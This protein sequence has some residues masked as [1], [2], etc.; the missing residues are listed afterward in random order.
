[1][2]KSSWAETT[3]KATLLENNH[4]PN[5]AL[6]SFQHFWEGKRST[7][8]L[9]QK[10][11]E[12]YITTYWD[13]LHWAKLT[14]CDTLGLWVGIA[15]GHPV[16]TYCRYDPKTKRISLTKDVTFFTSHMVSGATLKNMC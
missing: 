1:M 15:E 9:V 4:T 11:G 13:N 3:D 14:N 16:G 2:R 8:S 6:S 7:L 10:F 12:M 5:R